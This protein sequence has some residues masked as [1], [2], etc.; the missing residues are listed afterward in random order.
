MLQ[1][2]ATDATVLG[3]LCPAGTPTGLGQV[4]CVLAEWEIVT[5]SVTVLLLILAGVWFVRTRRSHP[6]AGGPHGTPFLVFP[7]GGGGRAVRSR[8]DEPRRRSPQTAAAVDE[9]DPPISAPRESLRPEGWAPVRERAHP[10][11]TDS[12]ESP[13]K[14]PSPQAPEGPASSPS[15]PPADSATTETT[16]R[17]TILPGAGAGPQGSEQVESGQIRY[18][19]PP[20]GT[21]Q[22]LPG[23]LEVLAN[24]QGEAGEEIRFVRVPGHQPELTFGRSD[25]PQYRHI[26]LRSPTVSRTHARMRFA[27]GRWTLRNESGT[28]PTLLNGTPLDSGVEAPTLADGDRIEMGEVVFRFRQPNVKD[29]LPFR[30]SWYTDQG[31]RPSN[32]DAVVV[33]SLSRGRELLAVCD[34]MG[35]HAMG[36]LASHAAVDTLVRELGEGKS[37]EDAVQSANR[38]VRDE[39]E[40][41]EDAAGL[42]TTLVALLRTGP[43]YQI[44]NVG[45]SR[46]YRVD[47]RGIH[48]ITQDHSF[49][50]EVVREGRMSAEEAGRSPWKSAITRHLGAEPDVEVDLFG[51]YP[52]DEPHVILLC[53]DGLHGVLDDDAIRAKVLETPDIR[54]IARDL[55]EEALRKGGDDNVTVAAME[56]EGGL[57]HLREAAP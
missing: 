8:P 10:K 23:R 9:E 35:S 48:R 14:E 3:F 47:A 12:A 15:A 40:A 51:A 56:F 20:D 39:L 53:S 46:A 45:D 57:R 43:E 41:D 27:D 37:L 17:R 30:S 49:V 31:R 29:R 2:P 28:N 7:T 5:L 50:A 22:L 24:G 42:G 55:G 25:G 16:S 19:R 44:A 11:P 33:K 32:Q 54:D 6:G 26:Q 52:A 1:Q 4:G 36:R 34:G 18:E 38:A 21:L 13:P